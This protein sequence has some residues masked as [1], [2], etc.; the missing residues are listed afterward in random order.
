MNSF[1]HDGGLNDSIIKYYE[2]AINALNRGES[3]DSVIETLSTGINQ[4][5]SRYQIANNPN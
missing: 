4:V 5:L 1:T 2:D 3:I